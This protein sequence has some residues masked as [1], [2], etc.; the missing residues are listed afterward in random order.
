[1]IT[2]TGGVPADEPPAWPCFPLRVAMR[3]GRDHLYRTLNT[4]IIQV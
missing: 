2:S 3:R 4:F 1:M